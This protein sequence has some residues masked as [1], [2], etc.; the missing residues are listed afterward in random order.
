GAYSAPRHWR[1]PERL[2]RNC[3]P[4]RNHPRVNAGPNG[5]LLLAA[6]HSHLDAS[7]SVRLAILAAATRDWDRVRAAAGPHGVLPL[8]AQALETWA[9]EAVPPA[10]LQSLHDEARARGHRSLR[11]AS[12]LVTIIDRLGSAGI[13][14]LAFK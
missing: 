7:A 10:V 14:V 2:G 4:P 8:L 1:I 11:L 5:A 12:D 3:G 9:H 6:A 13:P